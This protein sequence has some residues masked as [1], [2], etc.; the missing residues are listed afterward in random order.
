MNTFAV[1][2]ILA[3]AVLGFTANAF[4]I[5]GS[6]LVRTH[7]KSQAIFMADPKKEKEEDGMDL[8]LEQMF[9]L[10]EDA[11]KNVKGKDVGMKD[12]EPSVG[13]SIMNIFGGSGKKKG[14]K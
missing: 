5:G 12:A 11:D 2:L 14:G 4:K 8:D 13:E 9:D 3:L 6:G 1:A 10:F 7:S